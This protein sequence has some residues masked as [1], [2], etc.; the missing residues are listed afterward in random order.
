VTREGDTNASTVAWFLYS[1][2]L[3]SGSTPAT[4][5]EIS[6][7]ADAINHAVPSQQ[8]LSGSLR[9]LKEL[10][11]VTAHGRRYSLTDAGKTMMAAA[12]NSASTVSLVWKN[13]TSTIG[14]L[15]STAT[16]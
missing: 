5:A 7:L 6:G 14:Q 4:S 8:E 11:L 3:A 2:A 15:S 13:L 10:G 1:V 9:R 16:K 12:Q